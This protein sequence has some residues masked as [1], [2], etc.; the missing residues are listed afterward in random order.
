MWDQ[1][2]PISELWI[3]LDVKGESGLMLDSELWGG[4]PH[5]CR[6]RTDRLV[7]VSKFDYVL[8]HMR[9]MGSCKLSSFDGHRV[10]WSLT[11][12]AVM[13]TG[14]VYGPPMDSLA[15]GIM[16]KTCTRE[17]CDLTRLFDRCHN[18]GHS[19]C[20]RG[21][22]LARCKLIQISTKPSNMG[23]TCLLQ[24]FRRSALS[25]MFIWDLWLGLIWL[26]GSQRMMILKYVD[27]ETLHA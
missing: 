20:C 11:S 9:F 3:I 6:L 22:S 15:C 1:A 14:I 5:P 25:L 27:W 13:Y 7:R 2:G 12:H 10:G 18:C 26:L 21:F 24:S 17:R 8:T 4:S 19:W 23:D 16:W